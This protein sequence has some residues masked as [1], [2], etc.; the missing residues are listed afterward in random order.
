MSRSVRDVHLEYPFSGKIKYGKI[1]VL[2]I[3]PI[4]KDRFDLIVFKSVIGGLNGFDH[5][6]NAEEVI[7]QIYDC[8]NHNGYLFFA[9]NLVSTRFHMY[10]RNK[11]G[12]GKNKK[13][14]NYYKIDELT[15]AIKKRF[16]KFSY[17]TKGFLGCFGRNE[18]QK[19]ILGNVDNYIFNSLLSDENKYIFFCICR[20]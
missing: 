18:F 10:I 6:K 20:K 9:E 12:W 17:E 16:T 7:S 11:Y 19:R 4:Y 14:W 2:N 1:D 15:S 13:G 3:D 5:K 8:L